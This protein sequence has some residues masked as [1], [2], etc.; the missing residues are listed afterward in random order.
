MRC[1]C[2]KRTRPV[3]ARAMRVKPN[4]SVPL[5]PLVD[6]SFAWA[7]V[8]TYRASP[9]RPL[10]FADPIQFNAHCALCLNVQNLRSEAALKETHNTLAQV[11][12]ASRTSV[13]LE[14]RAYSS[15]QSSA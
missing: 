8:D 12:G 10:P 1:Q 11:T 13:R 2:C 7:S 6:D 5:L 14:I 15:M 3:E 4:V 9:K